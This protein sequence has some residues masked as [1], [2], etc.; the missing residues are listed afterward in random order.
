MTVA[1]LI[2]AQADALP[3]DMQRE[4]FDFLLFLPM[5]ATHVAHAGRVSGADTACCV[6]S[7]RLPSFRITYRHP[8]PDD[9]GNSALYVSGRTDR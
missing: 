9:R 4:A 1:E 8:R 2:R 5:K 3:E 6:T 7:V